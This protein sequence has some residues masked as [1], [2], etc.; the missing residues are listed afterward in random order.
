MR[1]KNA[2]D[3]KQPADENFKQ[4][5]NAKFNLNFNCLL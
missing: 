4:R 2:K 5:V 1:K 3:K